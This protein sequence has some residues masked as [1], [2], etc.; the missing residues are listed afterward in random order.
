MILVVGAMESKCEHSNG[1]PVA[2]FWASMEVRY[3][4]IY[5]LTPDV[6]ETEPVCFKV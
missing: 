1:V 4:S 2:F 6:I 3:T 5:R